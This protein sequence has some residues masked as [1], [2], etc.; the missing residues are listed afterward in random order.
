VLVPAES[1][2]VDLQLQAALLDQGAVVWDGR[3]VR[4][5]AWPGPVVPSLLQWQDRWCTDQRWQRFCKAVL[6]SPLL[7][8]VH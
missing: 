8:S 3:T 4:I 6:E 2:Q 5:A 1:D 7:A